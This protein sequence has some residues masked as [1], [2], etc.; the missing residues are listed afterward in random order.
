MLA[1]MHFRSGISIPIPTA[2][3]TGASNSR[4]FTL[5]IELNNCSMSVNGHAAGLYSIDRRQVV[6]VVPPGTFASEGATNADIVLNIQGVVVRGKVPMVATQ[7]DLFSTT[8]GVGGRALSFNATNSPLLQGEPYLV[9]QVRLR[10][11]VRVPTVIRVLMTGV[12]NVP[13]SSFR[14]RIGPDPPNRTAIPLNAG[15]VPDE[16][17]GYYR[18]EFQLIPSMSGQGDSVV[19]A[20][21]TVGGVVYESRTD[22]TAP[23]ILIVGPVPPTTTR[24]T[25]PAESPPQARPAVNGPPGI[26]IRK[27]RN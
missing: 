14:I 13:G 9:T 8:G 23:R 11:G 7:P 10:G 1:V 24:R 18:V 25:V 2:V 6:F 15:A 22:D 20:G 17:P 3:A 4:R 27:S 12:Q 26:S 19:V 16:L 21:I 5:P